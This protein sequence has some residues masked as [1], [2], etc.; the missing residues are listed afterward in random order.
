MSH[1]KVSPARQQAATNHQ[2]Y[3]SFAVLP[4]Y[5]CEI[6]A[7]SSLIATVW[8]IIMWCNKR[9]ALLLVLLLYSV[10]GWAQ[11]IS[12][13]PWPKKVQIW[14]GVLTLP[15]TAT[16]NYNLPSLQ[17]LATI[18]ADEI[19]ALTNVRLP[20]NESAVVQPGNILLFQK[21]GFLAE[22]YSLDASTAVRLEAT[23]L[24]AMSWAAV[25][26]LQ[27]LQV[28]SGNVVFIKTNIQDAPIEGYRGVLL[29]IVREPFSL[30]SIK[31]QIVLNRFYKI[32]FLVLHLTDDQGITF[33]LDIEPTLGTTN[34]SGR[35]DN[36]P[37]PSY[38]RAQLEELVKFAN[39][40]GI[41]LIP[42]FDM[43]GHGAALIRARPDLFKTGD[44]HH[45]TLNIANPEA[46]QKLKD[47]V[48][49]LITIFNSSPYF[50][51]GGD[52]ADF[53]LLHRNVNVAPP[54]VYPAVRQQW[55]Q[56][57]DTLTIQERQAGRL[58]PNETIDDAHAV[59]RQFINEMNAFLK[60]F[61][62]K[63]LVWE[64]YTMLDPVV[65]LNRD[66]LVMPYDQFDNATTYIN[67]GFQLINASW[68]PL[69]IVSASQPGGLMDTVSNIYKWNKSVFDVFYGNR[70]PT[71]SHTVNAAKSWQ[72]QGAQMSIWETTEQGFFDAER[73]RLPA[74]AERLWNPKANKL[75]TNFERRYNSTNA[76]L[77]RITAVNVPVI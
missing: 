56:R 21:P 1:L 16:I 36:R 71:S 29:D 4:I 34:E 44:Y 62:K 72:I 12:V 49:E 37:I 33:K 55:T 5:F 13:V 24:R 63:A 46:V 68:S 17:P 59:Y 41:T 38:T 57:L 23:N 58:G 26:L 14:G 30:E 7:T 74:M 66:V 70:T 15:P 53:D 73:S 47:I 43:P 65:P 28:Q 8:G 64:S 54:L 32:P 31:R 48:R 52:E 3:C 40:R 60:Q 69:Y 27:I 9:Q 10:F 76:L 67:A 39:D 6:M 22:E 42:E 25:T 18:L 51:L 61:K 45:A 11:E 19:Y 77:D 2:K 35:F 75:F 20:I 50:H